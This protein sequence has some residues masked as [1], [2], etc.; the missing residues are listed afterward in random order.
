MLPP[1]APR[2]GFKSSSAVGPNELKELTRPAVGFAEVLNWSVQVMV[3]GPV[4]MRV[5]SSAPSAAAIMTTGIVMRAV[6]AGVR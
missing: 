5:L 2:S 3:V 4:A 6:M 1:G